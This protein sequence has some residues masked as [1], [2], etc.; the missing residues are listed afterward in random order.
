VQLNDEVD[1]RAATEV[2]GEGDDDH[3]SDPDQYFVTA[4]HDF[5]F[6]LV[7]EVYWWARASGGRRLL[8]REV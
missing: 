3:Y 6:L 8:V 2:H 4:F 7:G 1:E 5:P